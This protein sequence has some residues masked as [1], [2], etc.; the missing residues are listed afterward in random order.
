MV[1]EYADFGPKCGENHLKAGLR[2]HRLG[3]LI[4]LF[5]PCWIYEKPY[6]GRATE[7]REQRGI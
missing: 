3:K 4:A 1:R 7:I 5:T 6:R 2:P